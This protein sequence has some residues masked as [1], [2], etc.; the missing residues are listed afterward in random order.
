MKRQWAIVNR[1]SFFKDNLMKIIKF[2]FAGVG[3]LL[4]VAV[5][6]I[7]IFLATFDA[8]QY[9]QDL[10]QLVKK[11]T[12][13][14]LEFE[15][16]IGLTL[17]PA[18]GMKLGSLSFSN[19]PGF[20]AQPM[21]AVEKASVS[22][23][24]LSLFSFSPQIDQLLLNGLN[25]N[26]QINKQGQTNWDDLV[27]KDSAPAADPASAQQPTK[28]PT[29]EPSTGGLPAIAGSFGGLNIT[30]AS[31]LWKDDSSGV[32]YQVKD[33]SLISGLIEPGTEFPL[34]L[35]MLVS[36][37]QQLQSS[38]TLTS[39][40]TLDL[41]TILLSGLKLK[42]SARGA[43][44]PV[45]KV[46][47]DLSGDVSFGLESNQLAIKGFT[48]QVNSRGGVL[49]QADVKLAGEIGFDLTKQLLTIA[50]L[51]LQASLLDPSLPAGKIK[52]GLSS[53]QLT[54]ALPSN[55][56][57]L[58]DLQL[59]L[60]ENVFKGFVK[61]NDY[62]RPSVDFALSAPSLNVDELMGESAGPDPQPSN[63]A[64]PPAEDVQISLPMELLRSL[65]LNG[66]LEVGELV[67]QKL[68][69]NDVLLEVT[70][71]KG[72]LDLKP[73]RMNLY[74]GTFDGSVQVNV[75]GKQPRYRV[76]KKLSSFQIGRFLM[77]FMGDDMVSGNANLSV[78]LQTGGEWL[79]ELKSRLDGDMDILVKDGA[80]KGFN[81][82]HSLESA[83]AKLRGNS[84]PDQEAKKTDFS[85]LSLSGVIKQ[86]VFTSQDLNMQA[87]LIR[88]NGKG[89]A[90]IAKETV[91]Y[92]VNAKV[93][94]TTKGQQGGNAD[95]L[96][97][98]T[99]PVAIT[100]AWMSPKIDVQLDE[101]LK[102]RLDA[103]KA[104]IS[105]QVAKEKAALQQTLAAEKEKLKAAQEKEAAAR[106]EQLEKQKQ[107]VEAEEKARLEAKKQ[108][109]QKKLEDKLKKLF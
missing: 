53:S 16:D 23:D 58:K 51:D 35:N 5:I 63:Q 14:E 49:Q 39:N 8:N 31:I 89:S 42:T 97:G 57:E 103:Q 94:G 81:L 43:I 60:N 68:T 59:A 64:E 22:V 54:M 87:P 33:L 75:Q 86:G 17:Y 15:G 34:E 109:A 76:T 19:A 74:D 100:G 83:K 73:L 10:A 37:P 88:V 28:E 1:S 7:G 13:R 20:G 98:M 55:S 93:V 24:V 26:L 3:I 38:V 102:A 50:V 25:V 61:V 107:L 45:D 96:S 65:Q 56:V 11:Q 91:D 72:V 90:D 6:G 101:M 62:T 104:R 4:L 40:V 79:S 82:R 77:D 67:A 21:L 70:A 32:E 30:N 66:K 99:I 36:S 85:A 108:E 41:P 18:L 9:K 80:L 47:I 52:T 84:V 12:G 92:L 29:E 106:K 69:F 78:N 27:A 48:T 71:N 44:I 2:L 46:D 105:E 95:E